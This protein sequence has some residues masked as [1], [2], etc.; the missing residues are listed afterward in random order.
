MQ[1]FAKSD[2]V[3]FWFHKYTPCTVS[4]ALPLSISLRQ[5]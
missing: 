4:L 5:Y 1:Q 3:L 2:V